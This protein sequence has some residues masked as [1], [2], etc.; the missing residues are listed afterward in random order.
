VN[1][2]AG[3]GSALV[4]RERL[5]SAGGADVWLIKTDSSGNM[6]WNKT[7]GGS[8][9]DYGQSVRQTSDGGYV[10]TGWTGWYGAGECEVCLIKT[11]SSGN[12]QWTTTF[13]GSGADV[14][15]SVQQTS[16]GGYIVV[17]TT[18]SNKGISAISMAGLI[19]GLQS[20]PQ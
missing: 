1:L 13:G 5:I 3:R 15:Y 10:I 12:V 9:D 16:D 14:G 19:S 4:N 2:S 6:S 11:D 7:F 17:G 20:G 8:Y 18:A